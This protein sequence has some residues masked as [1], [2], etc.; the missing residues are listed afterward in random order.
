MPA[1]SSDRTRSDIS[2]ALPG[3]DVGWR[4][5]NAWLHRTHE[6]AGWTFPSAWGQRGGLQARAGGSVGRRGA[7]GAGHGILRELPAQQSQSDLDRVRGEALAPLG[8]EGLDLE[9][10]H[11]HEPLI[12]AV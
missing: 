7:A 2:R 8:I 6:L 1:R 9:E 3:Q 11:A 4:A 10:L 5:G 12:G